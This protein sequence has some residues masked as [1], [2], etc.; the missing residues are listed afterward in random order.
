MKQVTPVPAYEGVEGQGNNPVSHGRKKFFSL[1]TLRMEEA[2]DSL[3]FDA[4]LASTLERSIAGIMATEN[5]LFPS[6]EHLEPLASFQS[7]SRCAKRIA[8]IFF[9][10]PSAP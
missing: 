1:T 3:I 7:A 8:N 6:M 10:L 2:P 5:K 9:S 4:F